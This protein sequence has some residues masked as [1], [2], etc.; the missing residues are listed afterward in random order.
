MSGNVVHNNTAYPIIKGLAVPPRNLKNLR[1]RKRKYPLNEM[2]PGDTFITREG[3]KGVIGAASVYSR[4][5]RA[6]GYPC[7]FAIRHLPDGTY[8]VQRVE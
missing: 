7:K 1:P 6:E 2:Q 3:E 8:F 5:R 4:S